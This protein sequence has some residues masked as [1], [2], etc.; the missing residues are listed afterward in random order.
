MWV[1]HTSICWWSFTGGWVAG[2]QDI[3]Q[4]SDRSWQ[5]FSL[6]VSTRPPIS[7]SHKPLRIVPS[8]PNTIGITVTFM[9]LSFRFLSLSLG[10]PPG[11]QSPLF[12]GFSFSC[13]L[14]LSLL[15]WPRLADQFG[16]ENPREFYASHFPGQ[17]LLCAYTIW[18]SGQ[19]L[20]SCTISNDTVIRT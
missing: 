12:R 7:N 4:Y 20:I 6:D 13:E 2:L 14:T 19:I 9:F 8:A 16:S 17:I 3:S 15:F 10:N 5:F 18:Q 1:F 11:Q